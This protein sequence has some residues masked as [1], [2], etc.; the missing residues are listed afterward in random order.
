[1]IKSAAFLLI[2][3]K[4][5]VFDLIKIINTNK[6]VKWTSVVYGPYQIIA[7]IDHFD[8]KKLVQEIEKNKNL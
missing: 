7:Y 1:M 8:E 2:K 3:T 4:I 5:N 6:I